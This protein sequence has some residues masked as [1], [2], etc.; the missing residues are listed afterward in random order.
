MCFL[1]GYCRVPGTPHWPEGCPYYFWKSWCYFAG[2]DTQKSARASFISG[3][4]TVL[5]EVY[6][7]FVHTCTSTEWAPESRKVME[8]DSWL[9]EC[10]HSS[11][12][13]ALS[14]THPRSF[15][16][17][18]A[19][20]TGWGC[21]CLWYWCGALSSLSWWHWEANCICLTYPHI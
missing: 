2:T 16:S 3:F 13:E 11:E 17:R 19:F 6:S 20:V 14:S 7:Q 15:W 9:Q 4:G 18:C 1:S 21:L 12:R 8:M 10:I 5:S